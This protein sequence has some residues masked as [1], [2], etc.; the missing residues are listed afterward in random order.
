MKTH[1]LLSDFQPVELCN[2]E[3]KSDRSAAIDPHFDDFWVWGERLVTINLV[4]DSILS[5][6]TDCE[7]NVEIQVPLTQR[8]LIVV[9]GD[10]RNVWKHGIHRKHI[11]G[12]RIAMT[13]R[14][15]TPEFLH[16]G[17]REEEGRKLLDRALSFNGVS[18]AEAES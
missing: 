18:V 6:T 2:L 14:E 11:E 9:F 17:E 12:T 13:L 15:L 1:K 5:F 10:A 4:S 16:D 7:L 3:Y 8:S